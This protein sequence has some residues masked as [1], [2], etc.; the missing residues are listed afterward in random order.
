MILEE[1]GFGAGKRVKHVKTKKTPEQYFGSDL[2][3]KGGCFKG[4]DSSKMIFYG[5]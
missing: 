1:E 5:H 2:F 4:Q 3:P